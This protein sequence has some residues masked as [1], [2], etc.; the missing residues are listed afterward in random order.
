MTSLDAV[1]DNAIRDAVFVM[2]VNKTF[3]RYESTGGDSHDFNYIQLADAL[4]LKHG[5]NIALISD[6]SAGTDL[7]GN[8]D[9]YANFRFNS[10]L[11]KNVDGQWTIVGPATSAVVGFEVTEVPAL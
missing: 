4:H 10:N 6:F 11:E 2:N 7:Q 8:A 3:G 1:T 5:I 9:V